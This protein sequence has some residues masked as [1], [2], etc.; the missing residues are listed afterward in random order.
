MQTLDELR[1]QVRHYELSTF[2]QLTGEIRCDIL[3]AVQDYQATTNSLE[4]RGVAGGVPNGSIVEDVTDEDEGQ[5]LLAV[6]SEAL[7]CQSLEELRA[8]GRPE[9]V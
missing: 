5:R 1:Q 6:Q 2:D 3:S 4:A 8:V 7:H 9:V